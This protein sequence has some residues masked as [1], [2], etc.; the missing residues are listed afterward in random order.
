MFLWINSTTTK[1]KATDGSVTQFFLARH[2]SCSHYF[3]YS[4][5]IQVQLLSAVKRMYYWKEDSTQEH[6]LFPT[7]L[8]HKAFLF[9][10]PFLHEEF[11]HIRSKSKSLGE[12][13]PKY[14]LHFMAKSCQGQGCAQSLHLL[15]LP[16]LYCSLKL[17][18]NSKYILNFIYCGPPSP[19]LEVQLFR[20]CSNP[21]NWTGFPLS[22]T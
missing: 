19:P 16:G 12:K 7:S 10:T 6:K 1:K 3:K 20:Y 17:C 15:E 21:R 9:Q 5:K 14:L 2:Q 18:Q 11:G 22:P 13:F 8:F 4:W